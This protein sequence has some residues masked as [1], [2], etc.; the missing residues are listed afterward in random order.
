MKVGEFTYGQGNIIVRDWNQN[1]ELTIGRFCSIAGNI[2]IFLG[3]EHET[4]FGSTFP[5]GLGPFADQRFEGVDKTNGDVNIGNDVWIGEGTTIMSGITISDGAVLAAN[6][7][8]VKDVGPYE[9]WGGNPAKLIK[10]RF[11]QEI[12][13]LML[14]IQ[15]WNYDADTIKLV[16]PILTKP[17]TLESVLEMKNILK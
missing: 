17:L 14:E 2:K 13:D 4:R 16:T 7:H 11:S 1:T 15:W 3:G 5:F 9:I 6:S 12:I 10:K 8:I